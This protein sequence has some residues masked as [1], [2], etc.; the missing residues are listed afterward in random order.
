MSPGG[1]VAGLVCGHWKVLE[2]PRELWCWGRRTLPRALGTTW[3]EPAV[4]S[5]AAAPGPLHALTSDL[6][7][8]H[9]LS[10]PGMPSWSQAFVTHR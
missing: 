3:Q 7:Q 6:L 4:L 10:P 9:V 1:S 8:E 2:G 5:F